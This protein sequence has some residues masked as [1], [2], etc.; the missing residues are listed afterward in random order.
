[1]RPAFV[2][3]F[4]LTFLSL[5]ATLVHAGGPIVVGGPKFGIDGQPFTWDPAKMPIQYRVDPGPMA[6]TAGNE[7]VIDNAAGVQRVQNMFAVWQS[8]PTA[9]I[10]FSN[11]G[12][13]LS[14]GAY[15]T[16]ADVATVP[17]FNDVVG[18]CK[19]AAQNPVMFDGNGQIMSG[20]GLPPGVIGFAS[21]C[22]LDSVTGHLTGALILMNGK[23]QDGIS[24]SSNFELTANEFD[25]AITHEIGHFLGLGHSQINI[26]LF[27]LGNV[28]KCDVDRLAG[29]PLM[30][31]VEFCQARKDAG[32][33]VLSQDDVSWISSLYPSANLVS[34]YGTI[35]GLIYFHDG[36]SQIQGVNVIARAVD[37]PRTPQDESR[38]IAVSAVSGYLF[39][40]NPGQSFTANMAD[41]VENNTNGSQMGSRNPKLIGYYQIAVPPGTYT[42]EVEAI[43][44]SF[45]GGSGVG[46]LDPPVSLPGGPEFWN[47]D[48]SA[49]DFALARDPITVNPGDKL[50][51]IDIIL[52]ND[53]TP[54]F[55]QFE[56]S[57]ALFA[58]P[59]NLFL[60]A[61]TEEWA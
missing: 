28:G 7:T 20:L 51:G 34:N 54:T 38:R 46:P 61:L 5:S 8:V 59:L 11:A 45:T 19:S 55:D 10:S 24:A 32:L 9:T 39:T 56:D 16:G 2:G 12:P 58:P 29:I 43:F 36:V 17:Q 33:P 50:T 41:P 15:V 1:M 21:G 25:E 26:D 52:N 4:L 22:A 44:Q 3:W 47:K 60:A 37:D 14:A 57:G 23:F 31:P 13:I 49:F 35:S 42:V 30:F 48:E 18:S 27:G 6:V 53:F 40:D